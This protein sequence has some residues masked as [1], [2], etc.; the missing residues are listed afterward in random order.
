MADTTVTVHCRTIYIHSTK[1]VDTRRFMNAYEIRA[2]YALGITIASH[3]CE[4]RSQITIHTVHAATDKHFTF[5]L[6]KTTEEV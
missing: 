4:N 6:G 5:F 3:F 1:I 2:R